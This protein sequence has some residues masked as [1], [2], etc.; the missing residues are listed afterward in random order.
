MQSLDSE[1]V[2]SVPVR[3]ESVLVAHQA[4]KV[5]FLLLKLNPLPMQAIDTYQEMIDE[6]F[7]KT[8]GLTYGRS[9]HLRSPNII[10]KE[11]RTPKA[12]S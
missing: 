8:G 12:Y 5:T 11:L 1:L 2:K 10:A 7:C 9:H 6:R 4:V 3:F